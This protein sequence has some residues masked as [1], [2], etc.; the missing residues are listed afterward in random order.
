MTVTCIADQ[1]HSTF[2]QFPQEST[3]VTH[4]SAQRAPYELTIA[5]FISPYPHAPGQPI[6]TTTSTGKVEGVGL[7][8]GGT[9]MG[10]QKRRKSR[11]ALRERHAHRDVP[12]PAPSCSA[13]SS[14]HA[15]ASARP[16]AMSRLGY[17]GCARTCPLAPTAACKERSPC[18]QGETRARRR[19]PLRP[20]S[21]C[22]ENTLRSSGGARV[23]PHCPAAACGERL[24]GSTRAF[25]PPPRRRV[26]GVL[27]ALCG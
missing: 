18:P 9:M 3:L 7:G 2:P 13:G 26:R 16:A 5:P 10:G 25:P 11:S 22:A 17:L 15:H 8:C 21:V 19:S 12:R 1:Y 23:R 20:A 4:D 6:V 24:A 27:I 14:R